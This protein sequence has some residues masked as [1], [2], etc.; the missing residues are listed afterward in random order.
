MT[1]SRTVSGIVALAV[2]IACCVA[3]LAL[4][5]PGKFAT[6]AA[7]AVSYASNGAPRTRDALDGT[8]I[9]ADARTLKAMSSAYETAA[10]LHPDDADTYLSLATLELARGH[11]VAAR[12]ALAQWQRLVSNR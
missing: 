1:D 6:G 2:V 9:S 7:S 12:Q 3:F 10:A 8:M 11:S 4:A 5:G